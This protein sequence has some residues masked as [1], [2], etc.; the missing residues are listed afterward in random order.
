M[1]SCQRAAAV[2]SRS[3]HRLPAAGLELV[4]INRL[5]YPERVF[6]A[7][8]VVVVM[9]IKSNSSN[10]PP[11]KKVGL[12]RRPLLSFEP[13]PVV[14]GAGDSGSSEMSPPS[15]TA[16]GRGGSPKIRTPVPPSRGVAKFCPATAPSLL[17][18][19]LTWFNFTGD[20]RRALVPCTACGLRGGHR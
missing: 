19:P 13:E 5:D 11:R 17:A 3:Q 6:S 2:Y 15:W 10:K 12:R 9:H 14:R 20:K 18:R 1:S 8:V 4:P 16:P 7:L